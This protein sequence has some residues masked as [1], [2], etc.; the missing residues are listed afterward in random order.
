MIRSPRGVEDILPLRISSYQW[1]ERE[2]SLLFSRYG[3]K[4][5]RTPIFEQTELFLRSIGRETDAGK[6]MYT[7]QDKK[8]RSLSLRP[9]ATASI[10]RAYIQHKLYGEEDLWRVYY[11]GSMFRYERPQRG[12]LR[13][14]HQIGVETIGQGSPWVDVELVE[15]VV[16]FFKGLALSPFYIRLNSI[17]CKECRGNYEKKLKKY[18]ESHL[19]SLCPV[20]QERWEL[21]TLRVLDCKNDECQ[22]IIRKAPG[23]EGYLCESCLAHFEKVRRGL[24]EVGV[25]FTVDPWLVRGLDYYTRTIFEIISSNLGAQDAVCGGGRY[26]DLVEDLGGPP[27]PAMGFSIG[28]ERLLE[29]LE[30]EGIAPPLGGEPTVYVVTLDGRSQIKGHELA[31]LL[32]SKGVRI[33]LNLSPRGLSSQ[34]K[35]VSRKRIRWTIIVGEKEIKE[36][37]VILRDMESG[38]QETIEWGKW[39][40]ITQKLGDRL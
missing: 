29:A 5:M 4:E 15:M 12:R 35:L 23:I 10:I 38:K 25:K 27:T 16:R 3:Y 7:F 32:R 2:A 36:K 1:V 24:E 9:E 13:E 33:Q 22:P 20:C 39:D 30:K 17:G 11:M 34:L 26:D 19:D 14:F 8:G 21:N 31:N 40:Q 18:L 37:T 6:N 28:V